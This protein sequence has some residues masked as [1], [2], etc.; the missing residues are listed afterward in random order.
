MF[1][2]LSDQG[3]DA[4]SQSRSCDEN[5][6]NGASERDEES[7]DEKKDPFNDLITSIKIS[8]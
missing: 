7:L 6:S 2:L 3:D 8:L 5:H 4:V 1:H